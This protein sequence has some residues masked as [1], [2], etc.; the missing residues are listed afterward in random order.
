MK[1]LAAEVTLTSETTEEGTVVFKISDAEDLAAFRDIVNGNNGGGGDPDACAKLTGNITIYQGLLDKVDKDG[2]LIEGS[3]GLVPWEPI[4]SGLSDSYTGT[5]DGQGHTISGLYCSVSASASGAAIAGLFH[6]IGDGGTVRDLNV[7]DSFVSA[8]G[9]TSKAGGICEYNLGAIT[10]CTFSGSVSAGGGYSSTAGGVC[11]ENYGDITGCTFSGSVRAGGEAFS[12]AGGVCGLNVDTIEN[13][14]NTGAVTGT[15]NGDIGGVCGENGN[16]TEEGTVT[17][18]LNTG[19]VTAEPESESS[20]ANIGGVCGRNNNG[21][22]VTKCYYLTGKDGEDG[23][24][25]PTKGIGSEREDIPDKAE[26]KTEEVFKS[27]AVAYLLNNESTDEKTAP[28]RQNLGDDK[29]AD[30]FPVLDASHGVVYKVTEGKY[31]NY[32]NG[33]PDTGS[34]GGTPT[35]R[36]DVAQ[37]DNGEVSVTPSHPSRGQTVTIT[38]DPDDGYEVGTVTVTDRNGN[39]VEVTDNGDGTFSFTQP[40]GKVTIAVTFVC[41]GGGLCVSAHFTDVDLDAWYHLAMDYAVEHGLMVGTSATTFSPKAATTRAQ[42]V[43]I[44]WRLEGSPVVNYPMDY[45]DVSGNVWYAEAV[46]WAASEGI[47]VGYGNGYFGPND[48]ILREQLATMLY[49]YAQHSGCD[50]SSDASLSGFRDAGDTSDYAVE[51]LSW[52]VETGLVA[53]VGNNTLDPRGT[54]ARAQAAMMLMRFC[55]LDK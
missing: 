27:G 39:E 53:G 3:S 13:C 54:A 43:T 17:N 49:R 42:L 2:N 10:G 9:G 16:R 18:C 40:F 44:L 30:P 23:E 41:D 37:S 6:T 55:E 14:L 5:F 46:R 47:A 33:K 50:T 31:S 4:G 51:A 24:G 8:D 7:A 25:Y 52:A 12:T 21:A 45:E 15:G 32:P 29:N 22:T 20:S 34:G 11:G 38:P 48:V 1:Y 26:G 35:Y 28:W 36:P 19:T